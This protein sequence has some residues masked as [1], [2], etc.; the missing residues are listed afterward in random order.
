MSRQARTRSERPEQI[1]GEREPPCTQTQR[2][3]CPTKL[4]MHPQS[5][6]AEEKPKPLDMKLKIIGDSAVVMNTVTTDPEYP[7]IRPEPAERTHSDRGPDVKAPDPENVDGTEDNVPVEKPSVDIQSQTNCSTPAQRLEVEYVRV[8]RV[9]AEELG[10]E[11]DVYLRERITRPTYL[12]PGIEETTPECNIDEANVGVPGV[13]TPEMEAK[14]KWI[15]KR[16]RSIF[17][18]DGNAAP[19]PASGVV[20]DIDVGEAKPVGL[21]SRQIAAPFLVKVFEFLKKLLEAELI[22][23]PESEWS[24]PIGIVLA[25][26]LVKVFEFL[27]K[28]LEAE[29]I[30]YPESEWSSPIGIVL[31]QNGIDIR[32]CIDYR[33]LNLIIKLSRYPLPLIDDLFKSMMWFMSLN[34]ASRFWAVRMTERAK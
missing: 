10:L 27:E 33:P 24:S 19:A 23:Y 16:H 32:M 3:Q 22:E 15:L 25:P 26:F 7:E 17:L 31:K 21:H 18:G 30:E 28:L 5:Q 6:A 29:H 12:G 13:T 14:M 4:L 8:M 2:Y 34:M 11:P 1:L 9:S 20:C